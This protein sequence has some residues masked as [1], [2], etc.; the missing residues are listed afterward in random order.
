MTAQ[1]QRSDELLSVEEF[2]SIFKSS[3]WTVRAWIAAGKIASV[4][5]QHSNRVLI[6]RAEVDRVINA[7]MRPAVERAK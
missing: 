2:A 4:K 1:A 3:H 7:G 6:P 5:I